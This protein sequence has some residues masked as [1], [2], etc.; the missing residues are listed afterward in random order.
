[1]TLESCDTVLTVNISAG[2]G[3]KRQ[4]RWETMTRF[5]T[6]MFTVNHPPLHNSQYI[7]QEL[8]CKNYD[9]SSS[10]QNGILQVSECIMRCDNNTN[11]NSSS[12]N[13]R[14]SVYGA[15]SVTNYCE[16]STASFRLL[17][18]SQLT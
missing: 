10:V 14:N 8:H 3:I 7:T 12:N 17:E 15:A 2:D 11:H 9:T 13:T 1:M 4:H 16:S 5:N 6:W 18:T